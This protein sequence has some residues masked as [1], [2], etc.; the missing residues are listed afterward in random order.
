MEEKR[1]KGRRE[2]VMKGGKGREG[3]LFFAMGQI[4]EPKGRKNEGGGGGGGEIEASHCNHLTSHHGPIP[5]Y[6]L[7]PIPPLPNPSLPFPS[8]PTL[9]TLS[10]LVPF[11]PIHSCL[12]PLLFDAPF[13]FTPLPNPSPI[14]FHPIPV[15]HISQP[16]TSKPASLP[17]HLISIVPASFPIPHETLREEESCGKGRREK[18]RK[19]KEGRRE[20][21]GKGKGDQRREERQRR[22]GKGRKAKEGK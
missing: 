9:L 7:S 8:L 15:R 6:P 20:Y 10:K 17:P 16:I 5:T 13:P 19:G 21:E 11:N 18:G 4:R 22:K 3:E 14:T 12:F 1:R 2:K